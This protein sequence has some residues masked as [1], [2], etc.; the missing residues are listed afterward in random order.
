MATERS[1]NG[2]N[3]RLRHWF[4]LSGYSKHALAQ[5]VTR[6]AHAD[7]HN[8]VAP[9]GSRVRRWL[10]DGEQPREPVPTILARVLSER[11]GARLSPGDLGMANPL[12][13]EA[14]DRIPHGP[15]ATVEAIR[16]LSRTDMLRDA[17]SA[18]EVVAYDI[19]PEELL[20]HLQ[21]WVHNSPSSLHSASPDS[22][23][24]LGLADVNR[25]QAVTEV[26]RQLDNA[27][28]GGMSRG[29]VIGQ[30]S[31]ANGLL[32][33]G[34]YSEQVSRALFS[35]VADLSGM[36]GWMSHDAGACEDAIR[37]L[38]L[39]VQAA[40]ESGDR[41]LAA[42]LL[43][44]LAR[45]YGY[46]GQPEAALEFVTLALYGSRE[47]ATPRIRAGLY[48]LE[49]RFNAMLRRDRETLRSIGH[50]H[51]AF[52]SAGNIGEEPGFVS[53]LDTSELA[54][55][56]GEVHLFLAR[57]LEHPQHVVPAIGLLESAVAL[58]PPERVRSRAFDA[59]GLCRVHL[60]IGEP[61]TAAATATSALELTSTLMSVRVTNRLRDV[62][63]ESE[64]YEKT[65]AIASLRERI[66]DRLRPAAGR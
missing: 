18:P 62:M 7:G 56:L 17:T 47:T 27:H 57:A 15:A 42:H 28:G 19:S 32:A 9:D 4:E 16:R 14:G 40:K 38:V 50:T 37:Y 1:T 31:W 44:C 25:V 21:P 6:R 63:R 30:L 66:S 59:I 35:T 34:T 23:G 13:D 55:T 65:P 64:P 3:E 58:R 52:S 11:T 36:A 29:A 10:V 39:A 12:D 60:A 26:F 54:S 61:E 46:I 45:V 49:G 51:D 2:P 20:T 33:N 48:A 24:A 22:G 8:H 53:Y 43:Q 41:N 5:E